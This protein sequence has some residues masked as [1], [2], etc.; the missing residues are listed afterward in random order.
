MVF[1]SYDPERDRDAIHRIWMETS[2][3]EKGKEEMMD[4]FVGSAKALVAELNGE[5]ETLVLSTPGT[6]QYLEQDLPAAGITGVT[7]S[8][9]ARKQGFASRLTAR[10]IADN[11]A[12]GAQ[13]VGLGMFD[14]GF[15]NQLGFGTGGYDHWVKFDPAYLQVPVKAR[16]PRRLTVE[17][18]AMVHASRLARRRLHGAFSFFPADMTRAEMMWTKNGFGL[19][20]CDGPNGELTHH[21]WCKADGEHGPYRVNWMSYQTMA[22]WLE[23]MA[24][25]KNLGDQVSVVEMSEPPG[26]QLQ[27]LLTK[28]FRRHSISEKS[29]YETGV[30]TWAWWQTRICDVPACLS[31]TRLEGE[32]VRFN[33][34]LADPIVDFLP[35]DA[36]WRGVGGEYVV[37]LGCT[38]SAERGIDPALPTL[39]ASVGAFTRLWLGVLPASGLAVTDNLAGPSS[40]I[41]ALDRIVRLPRPRPDW[42][43]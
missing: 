4:V 12:E 42:N 17:D 25:L 13:V 15:Y 33:L 1:R 7:T 9:I 2:W 39:S 37:T 11:A 18:Y 32:S 36:P 28:P 31:H 6:L 26:I 22:Q 35:E 40:L 38:S 3:L 8:R 19:G 16:V 29:K 30:E 10:S 21:L 43:F 24:L 5:A 23:L 14:Q 27:D 20:Y 34:Q 41:E